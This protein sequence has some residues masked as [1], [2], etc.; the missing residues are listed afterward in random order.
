LCSLSSK[1]RIAR[2][3]ADGNEISVDEEDV[4][5]RSRTEYR[6]RALQQ[7]VRQ[8]NASSQLNIARSSNVPDMISRDHNGSRRMYGS[9]IDST[10]NVPHAPQHIAQSSQDEMSPF[11]VDPLP[12]PLSS[13]IPVPRKPE[14][15]YVDIFVPKHTCLAGR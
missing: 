14:D 15:I 3:D 13:M 10:L 6:L 8:S 12:M 7:R 1:I 9:V 2:L 5:E 11:Y 4:L